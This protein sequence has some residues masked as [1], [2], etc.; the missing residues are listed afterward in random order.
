[1]SVMLRF[2]RIL[3]E[4]MAASGR[5]AMIEVRGRKS[6][7]AIRTPVGY[8]RADDASLWLGAGR[9]ESQWPRNL[10]ATPRC[11]VRIA[12][13]EQVYA[14][15]ELQGEE[16]ARAVAEIRAKYGAPAAS[17]GTGPVFILR[18]LRESEEGAESKPG[19]ETEQGAAS[20]AGTETEQGA[21]SE[22]GAEAAA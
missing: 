2:N 3:G 8:V 17:V 14:A 4:R 19:A 16:R 18:P 9:A 10:L 5:M 13:S 11:R 20:E 21:T 6:G 15:E 7:R 22:V 12:D 1:M